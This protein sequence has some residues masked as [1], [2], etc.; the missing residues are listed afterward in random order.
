MEALAAKIAANV[1][2]ADINKIPAVA[3][4]RRAYKLCGKDPNRYRPSQEQLM[5]R[6]VRGLGL[7]SVNNVV[8]LGN[9]LSLSTGCSVGC[10]D[11]DKI[12][13]DAITVGIGQAG[14]PYEGIGRGPI[15]IEGMP[16]LR[17]AAG[18]F[19]TPTS[20]SPRTA[21]SDN[22]VRLFTTMH[23]FDPSVA[24]QD[25]IATATR[26]FAIED[27]HIYNVNGEMA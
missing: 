1:A 10:F 4:T 11:L 9:I 22:T 15:N 26:L 8:D 27:C 20:D 16:V 6:I 12:E 18:A 24:A 17:D 21:I 13:G 23:L 5:R 14:E 7:Y 25:V 19:A 2:L 3:A